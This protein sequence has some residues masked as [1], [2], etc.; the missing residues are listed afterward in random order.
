MGIEAALRSDRAAYHNRQ[1]PVLNALQDGET[2]LMIAARDG[3]QHCVATLIAAGADSDA[4]DN[5]R[6]RLIAP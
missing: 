4:K 1:T 3:H 5:V 2:A 6:S